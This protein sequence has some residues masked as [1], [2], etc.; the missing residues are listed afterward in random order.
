MMSPGQQG[1]LEIINSQEDIAENMPN[2]VEKIVPVDVDGVAPYSAEIC[3][4]CDR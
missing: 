1:W 2:F 3:R 4:C